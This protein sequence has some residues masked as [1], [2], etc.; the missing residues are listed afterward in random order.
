MRKA[1]KIVISNHS[2]HPLLVMLEPWGEDYTLRA[3]EKVEIVAENR[4]EG[5]Y[6]T[7]AYEIDHVAVY[8]QGGERK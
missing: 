2:G 1:E 3:E 4:G 6:Y 5:F 7:D 8:A